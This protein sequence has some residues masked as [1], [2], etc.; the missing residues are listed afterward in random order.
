MNVPDGPLAGVR[1][2]DCTRGIAGPRAGGL[3][4]DYGADV[5]WVEPPGGCPWRADLKVPY[6]VFNRGKRS[7]ILDLTGGADRTRFDD[8]LTTGDILLTSWRPG[9]AEKLGLGVGEVQERFPQLVHAA[10]SGFGRDAAAPELYGSDA[11][12]HAYVGSMGEQVG[13]RPPP[14]FVGLPFASI[15]AAYL[16]VIGTLGALYK[17]GMD[18]RARSVE[19]SLLDGALAY[20]GMLWG[21]CENDRTASRV[22]TWRLISRTFRCADGRFVGVH[23]GARG[24]FGR[25]MFTLGFTEHVQS[26]SS[27]LD[28]GVP[29]TSAEQEYIDTHIYEVFESRTSAQWVMDLTEADVCAI[30]VLEP[31]EAFDE[32]QVLHNDMVVP[33]DDPDLGLIEQVAPAARFSVTPALV[34]MPAPIPG[35]HQ[36]EVLASIPT[37]TSEGMGVGPIRLAPLLDGLKVLDF[38]HYYAGPYASRFLADLGA[39]VIK[40]EPVAGDQARGL[41]RPFRS[42]QAGKRSIAVDLLDSETTAVGQRLAEWADVIHHNLRP[43]VAERL[44]LGYEQAAAVNP[45]VVYLHAPGWGTSG[46]RAGRQSFAPLMSG[47]VGASYE[48]AGEYNDPLFPVA[49]EDSGNG[50]LGAACILMALVHRQRSGQGQRIETPQLNAALLHMSHVVRTKDGA[51]LGASELD[52][53]Q[54]GSGPFER[55]VAT[56]DGWICFGAYTSTQRR[57]LTEWLG[58]EPA[59][60]ETTMRWSDVA[61]YDVGQALDRRCENLST[62]DVLAAFAAFG[63]SA[64]VPKV[65]NNE[66]FMLDPSHERSGRVSQYVDPTLGRIRD[67]DQLLR[68][69][70]GHL[71]PHRRAPDLG[72]HT[73]EILIELGFDEQQ[74]DRWRA[75]GRITTTVGAPGASG[76]EQ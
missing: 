32:P 63:V 56:A 47:Y 58:L 4:A 49:N 5:V 22:G 6:S 7:V 26:S 13:H 54:L 66:A 23:T 21:Y 68:V 62:E 20:L 37:A 38:G 61:A 51:V 42:A 40:L 74:I 9:V 33:V 17:R 70:D 19:T 73:T 36:D 43:G 65:D 60:S 2:I 8:L 41:K 24:A 27:G 16:A 1:V 48:V 25:L 12:V 46:P 15:G 44:G 72:E 59:I 11:M 55:L 18:D 75:D 39:E 71:P 45:S 64:A 50:M 31:G 14:I 29:L 67:L 35:E 34:R 52:V 3:L 57:S 10:I 69:A 30:E 76:A 28:V 53:L